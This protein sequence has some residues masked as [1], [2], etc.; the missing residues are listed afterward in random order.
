[1]AVFESTNDAIGCAVTMQRTV[2]SHNRRRPDHAYGLRVG[3]SAGEATFDDGDYFG[4][5]VVEA[6]RLCDAAAGGQVLVAGVVRILLGSAGLHRLERVG[7]LDLKGLPEPVPAWQAD[8][9][10]EEETTLRVALADD[11][12]LLREGIA[13]VLES[14]GIDVVFQASDATTLLDAV[15]ALGPDVVIMDVRMPPTHTTEGL[16]AAEEIRAQHPG[17]G[18]LVL[19]QAIQ[20]SAARRLLDG[21]TGGVG[22]MLKERVGNV[23][24]LVSAIRTVASGGSAIDPEVVHQ[25]ATTRTEV[26]VDQALR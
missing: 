12:V 2:A 23:D 1:M 18:V 25:L 15:G 7:D 22:Y 13:R 26:P 24:D 14:E 3:L 11:S 19:S 10:A 5:S 17:I 20:A 8:W 21:E 9:D 6:S 4:L 16:R